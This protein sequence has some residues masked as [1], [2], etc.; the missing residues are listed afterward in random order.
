MLCYLKYI[1]HA[2][3][4]YSAPVYCLQ[5]LIWPIWR[6]GVKLYFSCCPYLL[7][8]SRTFFNLLCRPINV[9]LFQW[10]KCS[11][12]ATA[13]YH[14]HQFHL[15]RWPH[16]I[17][18]SQIQTWLSTAHPRSR[19]TTRLLQDQ[20]ATR[21]TKISSTCRSTT[22]TTNSGSCLVPKIWKASTEE[23]LEGIPF[24]L[25]KVSAMQCINNNINNSCNIYNGVMWVTPTTECL[26]RS[27]Q[28]FQH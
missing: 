2:P 8:S 11:H 6:L 24:C 21:P 23:S 3:S 10:I 1:L 20:V 28:T 16:R 27:W 14:W 15:T 4:N 18:T 13:S 22:R 26:A 5:R 7:V 9:F 19:R 25:R 12:L 17:L